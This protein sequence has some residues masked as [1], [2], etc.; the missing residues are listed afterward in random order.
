M[1][2][3]HYF[4]PDVGG[5]SVFAPGNFPC[6]SVV[7]SEDSP[8]Q[9]CGVGGPPRRGDARPRP[10]FEIHSAIRSQLYQQVRPLSLRPT[11]RTLVLQGVVHPLEETEEAGFAE[12]SGASPLIVDIGA[13]TDEVLPVS[14]EDWG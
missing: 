13:R 7:P 6:T 4:R 12:D 1:Y 5:D 3:R 8:Q 14:E 9:L 11:P 2:V 10:W